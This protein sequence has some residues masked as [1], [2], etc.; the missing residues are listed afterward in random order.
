MDDALLVGMCDGGRHRTEDFPGP[1][2]A[3][4]ERSP[5][6]PNLT[7]ERPFRERH[8]EE[9]VITVEVSVQYLDDVRVVE[10]P[11]QLHLPTKAS[12]IL[13]IPPRHMPKAFDRQAGPHDIAL[14]VELIGLDDT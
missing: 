5:W 13:R 11:H 8:H 12:D 2:F 4:G 9:W 14:L 7:L 1:R 10:S 6:P 3:H